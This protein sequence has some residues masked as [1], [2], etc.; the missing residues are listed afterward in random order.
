MSG[1]NL[2]LLGVERSP[3]WQ[4]TIQEIIAEL[5][6]ELA[7]GEAVYSLE[8]LAKL[9]HKLAEYEQMLERLLSP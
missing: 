6:A 7:K 4:P 5:K 2:R 1:K 8:E 3:A 9:S